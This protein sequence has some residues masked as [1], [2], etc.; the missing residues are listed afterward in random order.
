MSPGLSTA[1]NGS[2]PLSRLTVRRSELSNVRRRN[3]PRTF[4]DFLRNFDGSAEQRFVLV[5]RLIT[6]TFDCTSHTESISTIFH[7]Y[8]RLH[9]NRAFPS[10]NRL[11]GINV[12]ASILLLKLT[13][14][15]NFRTKLSAHIRASVFRIAG[16]KFLRHDFTQCKASIYWTA[17]LI[18]FPLKL[19][20]C[21]APLPAL[22]VVV[23]VLKTG[24][25][26]P[27]PSAFPLGE[28]LNA[29]ECV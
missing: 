5:H 17:K 28:M 8:K 6:E 13:C 12:N 23:G 15:T 1:D 3:S 21:V 10:R 7:H 14:R 25:R 2:A 18:A 4:N 29:I 24:K 9:Y 26:P 19:C 20:V 16:I 27:P 11:T 22:P